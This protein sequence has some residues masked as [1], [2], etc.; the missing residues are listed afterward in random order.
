MRVKIIIASIFIA[1]L[2]GFQPKLVVSADISG[3]I[4]LSDGWQPIIFM[5]SISSPENLNVASPDFIISKTLI[6]PNG[7]FRF[8]NIVLPSEPQFYRFYLVKNENSIVEFN[9]KENRN[10]VHFILD[11]SSTLNFSAE[12][13]ENSLNI[14]DVEGGSSNL[15]LIDF[16]AGYA[17]KK[18]KLIGD[19]SKAQKEFLTRDLENYIRGFVD[20]CE[21]SMVGLYA[22]YHIEDKETDFLRNSDFYFNFQKKINKEYPL[23]AFADAYDELLKDLVGFREMVCEIP[24]VVPKWKDQLIIVE[25]IMIFILFLLL[26][27]V[28]LKLRNNNTAENKKHESQV[29]FDKLTQKEKEILQLLSEGKTNK[30]IAIGLFVELSTVKTHINSIYRQIEVSNRKE[31]ILFF[32]SIKE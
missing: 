4:T 11:N 23:S 5:A 22:L 3:N 30:E 17:V 31:A 1:L 9:V 7:S 24:G 8:A 28:V 29:L 12:I 21:N 15:R 2:S 26:M 16:E 25:S 27:F 14:V 19:L 32:D 18:K 10:F 6:N 13:L 20:S